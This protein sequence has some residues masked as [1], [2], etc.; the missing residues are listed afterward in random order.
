MCLPD[1]KTYPDETLTCWMTGF[2]QT[3]IGSTDRLQEMAARPLDFSKCL[4]YYKFQ[5][6]DF[7]ERFV[8]STCFKVGVSKYTKVPLEKSDQFQK[9]SF[10]VLIQTSLYWPF[11]LEK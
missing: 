1:Y 7:Q 8:N 2:G 10:Y 6:A 9:M 5:Y 3:E 11:Y 4:K